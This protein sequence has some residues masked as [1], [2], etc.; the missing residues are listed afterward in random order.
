MARI[1]I[2]GFEDTVKNT[3]NAIANK[4][5]NQTVGNSTGTGPQTVGNIIPN[6]VAVNNAPATPATPT[7]PVTPTNTGANTGANAGAGINKPAQNAAQNVAQ[8]VVQQSSSK[9]AL[10]SL[11]SSISGS[12]AVNDIGK[13][14]GKGQEQAAGTAQNVSGAGTSTGTSTEGKA[15]TS[16][17]DLKNKYAQNLR[18]QYDYSAQK[19]KNER[20]AALRENWVLQQQAEAALPEQMA[21]AGINGGA[22]ETTLANLRAKYQGDRNNIRGEY[23]NNLGELSQQN[24]SER[25]EAERAYNEKWLEYLLSLAKMEAA[26]EL[27]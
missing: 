1:G 15:E 9:N 13:L 23:M 12:T 19:L 5:G 22:S 18:D 11:I 17:G 3:V 26:K 24:Q 4:I 21:A 8:N 27:E 20:D 16:I 2:S 10:G 7:A 6:K 25:A 14:L